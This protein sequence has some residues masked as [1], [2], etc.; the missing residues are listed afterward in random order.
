MA[1]L[2]KAIYRFNVIPIKLPITFFTELEQIIQKFIL[3]HKRPT[4]AKEILREE[5]NSRRHNSPRLQT[6]L[7]SYSNQDNVVL[8]QK[9][10]YGPMQQDREPSNKL[11]NLKV[12]KLQQR[13]Q[14]YNMGKRHSSSSG[15]GKLDSC[16]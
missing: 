5:K 1:I 4:I 14:G 6:V 13:R 15:A 8:V 11:R 10:A 16:L 3:N 12:I 9:Q 7:Q 2:P